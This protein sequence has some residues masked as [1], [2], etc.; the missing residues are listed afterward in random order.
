MN[1]VE[2]TLAR[3]G[4]PF[5]EYGLTALDRYRGKLPARSVDFYL[6][7]GSIVDLAR[8]F[9][10]LAYPGLPYADAALLSSQDG[11][12]R[13]LCTENIRAKGIGSLALSDFRRNPVDGHFQDPSDIYSLLK[14]GRFSIEARNSDNALFETA[15][16][17]SRLAPS[18]SGETPLPEAPREAS[19]LMQRDLLTQILQGPHSA[20][21]LDFLERSGF[22]ERW[23]PELHALL[24]VDHAK[25][26]HPEGGGWSHTMEAL[27]HRKTLDL[28][29]SLA[30][31]LHDIGKPLSVSS[32]GR[33]FDRHAELGTKV[34]ARFLRKLGFDE[35]IVEDVSYMV[36]WH[37]LPAALPRI[38]VSSVDEI[39]FDRR[40]PDLLELF[41]CD[42][43][44]S[45]KGPD[46]YYAS[47][48][49][50]RTIMKRKK[51]VQSFSSR[52]W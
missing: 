43:F 2:A 36:R 41:R 49:A 10:T 25:D 20:A 5:R 29:L 30:I 21:A 51:S 15:L 37:M 1:A 50:Y 24:L 3:S 23:W 40:F 32:E 34:A 4:M 11:E 7:E 42:E 45:F 46:A 13:F 14:E 26:C 47:C 22:V 12:V 9:D 19:G 39:V 6:V 31:L 38:P 48:A 27:G 52:G 18:P 8:L 17:L 28:T 16:Y 35:H 33:R 44:S